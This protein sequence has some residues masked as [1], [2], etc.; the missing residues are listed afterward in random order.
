MVYLIADRGN[1]LCK[2]GFTNTEVEKRMSSLK[3]GNPF[4]L[5][6]LAVIEGER[7]LEKELHT[8]FKDYK[9]KGEWFKLTDEIINYFN[10]E[11]MTYNFIY[12]EGLNKKSWVC[13]LSKASEIKLM[14]LLTLHMKYNTPYIKINKDIRKEICSKLNIVPQTISN[15]ITS[16]KNH[17]LLYDTEEVGV[18]RYNIKLL[19]YGSL[20]KREKLLKE[21]K[22]D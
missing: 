15:T 20:E 13:L 2:I 5:E 1:E 21:Y 9:V 22:Y 18:Y 10:V 14:I 12:G 8:K 3:T 11:F 4:E 17:K 16:L 19:W 6:V 7:E